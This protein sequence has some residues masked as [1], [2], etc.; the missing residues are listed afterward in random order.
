MHPWGAA[1]TFGHNIIFITI[2]WYHN[3]IAGIA[4]KVKHHHLRVDDEKT[5]P[6]GE[7]SS[8]EATPFSDIF[9]KPK[10]TLKTLLE[11]ENFREIA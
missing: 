7:N 1:P 6:R 9:I 8:E 4:I 5:N 2:W 10:D 11:Y 3:K